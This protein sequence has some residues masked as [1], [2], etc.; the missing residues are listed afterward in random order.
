MVVTNLFIIYPVFLDCSMLFDALDEDCAEGTSRTHI[1]A[2]SAAQTTL[3]VDHGN[4]GRILA[5]ILLS[6]HLYCSVGAVTLAVTAIN[7]VRYDDT[8]LFY[9]Y[10][11]TNLNRRLF[12]NGNRLNS[13][14]RANLLTLVTLGTAVAI[15]VRHR[16]LHKHLQIR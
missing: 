2:C 7:I 14:S 8:V 13:A 4:A 10:S 15:L 12:S 5:A 16:G 1:F 11:V 9:P 3:G 6:Y